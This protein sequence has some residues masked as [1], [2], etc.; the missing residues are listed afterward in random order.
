MSEYGVGSTF[1]LSVPLRSNR[2][3]ELRDEES[4]TYH[5]IIVKEEG[6]KEKFSS[7]DYEA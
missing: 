4:V 7:Q 2:L 3:D 1:I 5:S 6:P